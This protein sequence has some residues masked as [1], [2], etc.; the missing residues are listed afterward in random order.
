MQA[1]VVALFSW[2][3]LGALSLS[4]AIAAPRQYA[5]DRHVDIL[6][7]ALDVTPDFEQ[8]TVSGEATLTFK[9]IGQPLEQLRLDA[10][11]LTV[12]S[13]T[14]TERIAGHQVT[15]EAI[16]VTFAKLVPAGRETRVTIR[17]S[18]TPRKGLYFRAP[19]TGYPAEEAHVW[20]QGE[21]EEARHWYPCYDYPNEK[22]TTEVTCRVPAGM[23][24]LS[25]GRQVSET[26]DSKSGLVAVTW[27]QEQPHVNYLL[28]LVAGH[29]RELGDMHGE[30]PLK[31][32]VLPSDLPEATNTFRHTRPCMEFLEREIGVKF[33]WAQY[34]QVVIRDFHWGGMENTTLTTLT[35]RTLHRGDTENLRSSQGLVAHELAHQWFGDL[36]T[37]RD[38]S[39]AWLN[40]G[41]ATY[42]AALY[43]EQTH[44]PDH[45]RL[46]QWEAA[47]SL[48]S[49]TNPPRAITSREYT[50]PDELFR[51][52]GYLAYG[53]GAWILHMLRSQLGPELYRRCIRTYVERHQF[54]TVTTADL[55]AVIEELSGRSFDRFFDQWVHHAGHPVLDVAYSWDDKAKLARV[56]IKQTQPATADVMLFRFPL[57]LRFKS[58]AGTVSHRVEVKEREEDFFVPL[59]QAPEIVRVD[60]EVTV[61]AKINFKPPHAMVLAQLADKSDAVGRALAAE[62][63]ADRRDA[64]AV[65]RLKQTLNSD[66]FYGVRLKASE[67]LRK[68]H[69]DAALEALLASLKQ[70]DARVRDAVVADLGKFFDPRARDALLAVLK[71]ERNP[72]IQ[73][74]ALAGL[75]PHPAAEVRDTLLAFLRKDSYRDQ[76][77]DAAISAMRAQDDP[78]LAGPLREWLSARADAL[79]SPVLAGALDTLAFL[80]RNET[81]RSAVRAALTGFV[82]HKRERI[83]LAAIRAL[84][85]LEDP[86][87]VPVL[88]TFAAMSK[89]TPEQ[90]AAEQA[91]AQLRGQKKP[92]DNLKD[93][94]QELLDVKKENRRLSTEL[95]ALKKKFDAKK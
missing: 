66:P 88:E 85:T 30:L 75:A 62:W 72:A 51:A 20:T 69:S 54:G 95:E 71:T 41:F 23:R 78:T 57:E 22:F 80:A 24:V 4:G 38:W 47:R 18:A 8:C 2:L 26:K 25:N 15:D 70:D 33:P 79:P 35:D 13:V 87:A 28:A 17:Y 63:L 84:G 37:C 5:P 1:P 6:H 81:D 9:P 42:Y 21:T 27:R 60:P 68:I 48:T 64:D 55:Q 29:F 10:V 46:G 58:K 31:F 36:V 14:S 83:R 44:G 43:E 89:A 94:R 90:K 34:G 82:N 67:S 61:L 76:L 93:V 40:E 86:Q 11:D 65:A 59:K 56:S 3:S 91:I 74:R 53:K 12:A 7:L 19:A 32:Y 73:M 52:H 49:R 77:A 39:Q 92:A 50:E 16:V 45:F